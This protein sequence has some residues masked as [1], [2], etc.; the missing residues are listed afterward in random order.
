MVGAHNQPGVSAA[1]S[2]SE[3]TLRFFDSG[4]GGTGRLVSESHGSP[5]S[6]THTVWGRTRDLG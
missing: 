2:S 6:V 4:E 3:S 5:H 1:P